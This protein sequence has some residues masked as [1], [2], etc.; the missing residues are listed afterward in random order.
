MTCMVPSA[1]PLGRS[2]MSR[3]PAAGDAT[4][5]LIGRLMASV[6]HPLR[7]QALRRRV[8]LVAA[9]FLDA[10]ALLVTATDGLPVA[11]AGVGLAGLSW[12]I[13]GR[14]AI[15]R[16]RNGLPAVP[17]GRPNPEGPK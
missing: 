5:G 4:S 10:V 17:P 1:D 13:I 2:R 15:W 3:D 11:F 9:L 16:P 14:L 7:G 12:L 8:A 6:C